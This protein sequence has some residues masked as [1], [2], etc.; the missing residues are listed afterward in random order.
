MVLARHLRHVLGGLVLTLG[1]L[2]FAPAQ[3]K[4]LEGVHAGAWSP[5]GKKISFTYVH[6]NRPSIYMMEV[7]AADGVSD[8]VRLVAD[9]YVSV[10]SPDSKHIAFTRGAGIYVVPV[11]GSGAERYI[12]DGYM[13]SW[14]P[15]GAQIIFFK[16]PGVLHTINVDGSKLAPITDHTFPELWQFVLSP[17]GKRVALVAMGE[18]SDT[19]AIYVLDRDGSN[20]RKLDNAPP[21]THVSWS[22]DGKQ[23]VAFSMCG[24][25]PY[26]CILNA[27]GTG[28]RR[29]ADGE[30]PEWSPDGKQIAY[31]RLGEMWITAVDASTK[32][33]VTNQMNSTAAWSPDSKH[34]LFRRMFQTKSNDPTY[35]SELYMIGADGSNIQRLPISVERLK[36]RS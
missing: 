13:P 19:S 27:D 11:N 9:A 23:L 18:A 2:N 28:H 15:D 35:T 8:P 14:S 12:T 29:L 30:A 16:L 31:M 25:T 22:P 34:I 36:A 4:A 7:M 17:D 21:D 1:L 10:W 5:D 24:G 3:A 20:M 33:L 32:W 26:L 6:D